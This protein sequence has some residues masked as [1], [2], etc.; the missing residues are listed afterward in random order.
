MKK[1]HYFLTISAFFFC[2]TLQAQIA[3]AEY[4]FDDDTVGAAPANV[5]PAVGETLVS[6]VSGSNA[7]EVTA[8]QDGGNSA[9][10]LLDAFPDTQNYSVTWKQTM[11]AENGRKT[12]MILRAHGTNQFSPLVK[13]GYLFNV[14]NHT[15]SDWQYMEIRKYNAAGDSPAQAVLAKVNLTRVTGT[16]PRW[17]RATVKGAD[18]TFEYSDDGTTWVT[19]VTATDTDYENVAGGTMLLQGLSAPVA[20]CHFDDILYTNLDA[21]AS[22]N[23]TTFSDYSLYPSYSDD[24][25]NVILNKSVNKINISITSILGKVVQ[26]YDE[27][28]PADTSIVLNVSNLNSGVYIVKIVADGKVATQKIV[29]E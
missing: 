8:F 13:Q 29:K 16:T 3:S 25:I 6:S 10:F 17:Y 5:T 1:L 15:R 14:A 22:I 28:N 19:H 18:L 9:S 4:N 12:G 11:S 24:K 20:D 7:L 21:T 2:V 23:N 27:I 26:K